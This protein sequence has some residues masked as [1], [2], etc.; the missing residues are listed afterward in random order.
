M[1]RN[2]S[3][4]ERVRVALVD[5]DKDLHFCFKKIL[6]STNNFTLA[7]SFSNATEA[8][9]G[10][11]DL[12]PDVTVMDIRLPDLNGIECTKRLKQVMPNLKIVIVTGTHEAGS[13]GSSLQA[14][15]IAYL[16]KPLAVDQLLATLTFAATYPGRKKPALQTAN[17]GFHPAERLRAKFALTSREIDVLKNLAEGLLYKEIA[18]K[19]GIT[20]SAV[21]KSQHKLFKKL[22]VGNR[23]EAARFWLQ[24]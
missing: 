13:V 15:A 11:P 3:A 12:C 20:Y 24:S 6:Q 18:E 17:E 4:N 8:L 21:H 2:R 7:G 5:D 22:R 9:M 23:S 10:I 16:V 19:L 1:T 14:G